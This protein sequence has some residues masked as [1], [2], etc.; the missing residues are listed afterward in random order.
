MSDAKRG[1]WTALLSAVAIAISVGG[2]VLAEVPCHEVVLPIEPRT[3]HARSDFGM[4]ATG[5]PEATE[6]AVRILEVGGNAVDAA[7][8]AALTL[9]VADPDASGL[10]GMTLMVIH[11]ATDKTLVIDGTSPTPLKVNP[12]RLRQ[13]KETGPLV[14]E[15]PA[16]PT[17][18]GTGTGCSSSRTDSARASSTTPEP[19]NASR[20]IPVG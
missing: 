15:I 4:V 2:V 18:G 20:S 13:L 7:V 14:F 19:I 16:G 5:S 1:A 6:A 3:T 11:L 8:A 17:A 9:G 10:G 12:S